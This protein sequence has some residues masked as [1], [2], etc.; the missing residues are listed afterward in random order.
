M[1]PSNLGEDVPYLITVLV[2][3]AG[4]YGSKAEFVGPDAR[5]SEKSGRARVVD[6]VRA[7]ARHKSHARQTRRGTGWDR[8][9]GQAGEA[10]AKLVDRRGADDASVAHCS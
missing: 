8:L 5:D 1:A 3:N 9:H 6:T 10:H 2:G 7:R 4:R